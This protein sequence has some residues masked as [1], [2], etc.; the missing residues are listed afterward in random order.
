M[1]AGLSSS[2]SILEAFASALIDKFHY[3]R[4]KV[5]SALCIL[6][7]LGGIVF[8]T[9]GGLFW[10][11]IVD[12]FISHYGLVLVGILECVLVGWFFRIEKIRKHVNKVSSFRLGPWWDGLIKYFVPLVLGFIV[13]GDLVKEISRPYENYSW[14][15]IILIGRDWLLFT[16]IV[17]FLL[18]SRPWKT[19]AHRTKGRSD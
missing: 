15:S 3:D 9:G 8:T 11:D 12:H 14:T 2:I 18:A 16:L 7:F 6:G 5:V 1:V 10:L 13:L 19:D 17:A 4:K